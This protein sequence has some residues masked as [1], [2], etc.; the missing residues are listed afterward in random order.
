MSNSCEKDKISDCESVVFIITWLKT[1]F[2]KG[3][4]QSGTILTLPFIGIHPGKYDFQEK[5]RV[6][7]FLDK[8]S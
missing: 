7:I 8:F 3:H 6:V 4:V 1:L 5:C 2:V